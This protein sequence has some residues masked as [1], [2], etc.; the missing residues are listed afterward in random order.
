MTDQATSPS[1]PASTNPL[2]ELRSRGEMLV[3]VERQLPSEQSFN[4]FVRANREEL[5]RRGAIVE[6]AGRHWYHSARFIETMLAIGAQRLS[7]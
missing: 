5:V 2:D 1:L 6:I 3:V 4:W 7:K